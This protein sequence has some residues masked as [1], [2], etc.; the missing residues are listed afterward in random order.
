MNTD[1]LLQ[2]YKSTNRL[3][4][5]QVNCISHFNRQALRLGNPIS[6]AFKD[7]IYRIDDILQ[8]TN[9]YIECEFCGYKFFNGDLIECEGYNL[10]DS[11]YFENYMTCKSC[12]CDVYR[13]NIHVL[14]EC[15]IYCK[16]CYFKESENIYKKH[17]IKNK[18]LK[19]L[20][21]KLVNVTYKKLES[22]QFKIDNHFWQVEKHSS[23]YRLGSWGANCW[24]DIGQSEANLLKAIDCKLGCNESLLTRIDTE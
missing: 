4:D 14:Y 11:C 10:C 6:C 1:K 22:I 21:D 8:D 16:D 5:F 3:K 23:F 15:E 13:D 24:I 7:V 17:E 9:N 18:L 20:Q 19:E 2:K 12:G